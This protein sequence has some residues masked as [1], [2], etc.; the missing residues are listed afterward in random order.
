MSAGMAWNK[1]DLE[2]L[3]NANP[4][5]GVARDLG[6]E[7]SNH[8]MRCPMPERHAHGDRTPSVTFWP[9]KGSYKCW[10]CP[11]VRGDVISLV[12]L[13]RHCGFNDAL[14]WLKS[15]AGSPMH[16]GQ[17]Q[18]GVPSSSAS[19]FTRDSQGE[20]Q[21]SDPDLLNALDARL[22]SHV[23]QTKDDSAPPH[24]PLKNTSPFDLGTNSNRPLTPQGQLGNSASSSREEVLRR[25]L[26]LSAPIAGPAAK[27][28]QSRRIFKRTW[29]KQGLRWIDNYARIADGLV[30]E[31][32]LERLQTLGFFNAVGH[33][34]Y[35][36]HVLLLPYFDASSKPV[37]LQ[38][39]ALHPDT[40]PKELSLSGPIPLPYNTPLLRQ[41][42]RYVYLCEGVIDTLT[43]LEQ[44][45][46][47][48]GIPGA[49][50]FKPEWAPYF[51]DKTVFIVFDPDAAGEAGAHRVAALLG[52]VG[53][54]AKRAHLP[55]GKDINEWLRLGGK[56]LIFD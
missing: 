8:R 15:R 5:E 31:F 39:R 26:E 28:L 1:S 14:N 11:E 37:Y 19:R 10:V 38:V 29:E 46:P 53:V 34:R 47:A 27:Y 36:R 13:L 23:T 32:G 44:G 20:G 2:A 24:A 21:S 42:G 7:L 56:Q 12:M 50:N 51:H 6:A 16:A 33:F 48:L 45:F 41:P 17:V 18:V 55:E 30:S 40:I 54:S 22:E 52:E 25:L 4:I 35:Y 49:A 3:K 9:A 43:L